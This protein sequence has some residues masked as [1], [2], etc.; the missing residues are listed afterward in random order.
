MRADADII[1]LPYAAREGDHFLDRLIAELE[2]ERWTQFRAAVAFASRTGNVPDLLDALRSFAQNGRTV[3][4]TF[5]A[6]RYSENNYAT[7]LEA[8]QGVV[9]AL[10]G[11]PDASVHLYVQRDITFHPKIYLF[12]NDDEA[13]VFIG[14]SNWNENAWT[15]NV[16]ANVALSL[17]LDDDE[18]R[19]AYDE[20]IGYFK[21]FW[22]GENDGGR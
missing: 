20:L 11:S 3:S 17:D 16:E 15:R 5:Y 22:T 18:C 13:L 21:R 2:S 7:D 4:I 12:A 1:V 19:D 14:S 9:D 8:V 10:D 6:R